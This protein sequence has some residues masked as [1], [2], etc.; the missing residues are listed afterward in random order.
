MDRCP[1]CRA[2]TQAHEHEHS[3]EVQLPFTQYFRNDL[4]IVPI[5]IM[6]ADLPACESLGHAVADAIRDWPEPALI[7]G[8]TDMTHYETDAQ[9]RAQDREAIQKILALDPEGLYGV[10]RERRISMC[11]LGPT[12]GVL[13]A[14]IRSGAHEAELVRYATSAE[15]GGEVDNVVGYAGFIIR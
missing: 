7:L 2:D 1:E 9:A 13:S 8:T 12:L 10:V 3:L 11:G 4:R 6:H 5:L 15:A 14:A